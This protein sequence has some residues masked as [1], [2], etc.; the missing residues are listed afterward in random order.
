MDIGVGDAVMYL[1]VE[2]EHG[3]ESSFKGDYMAQVF[4]HYVQ[5]NG[6]FSDHEYDKINLNKSI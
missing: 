4:L 3:R 1:G 5:K 2:L 6:V